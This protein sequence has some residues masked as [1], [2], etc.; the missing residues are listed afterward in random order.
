MGES[1][2]EYISYGHFFPSKSNPSQLMSFL[3]PQ[4]LKIRLLFAS[5]NFIYLNLLL[6]FQELILGCLYHFQL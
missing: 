4:R 3:L 2:N 5:S 1:S 6:T